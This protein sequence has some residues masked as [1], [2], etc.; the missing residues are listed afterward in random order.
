M[1]SYAIER[2]N[3]ESEYESESDDEIIKTPIKIKNMN[4]NT[5]NDTK[6]TI[7]NYIE[8]ESESDDEIIIIKKKIK[9]M[10]QN[11]NNETKLTIPNYIEYQCDNFYQKLGQYTFG[12]DKVIPWEDSNFVFSG[13]LLYDIVTERLDHNLMDIDLF[14]Y[15][16]SKSKHNTINKLLDNLDKEQYYYLIGYNGSVIYIFIQGLPRI[17]QL[18]MTDKKN[19]EEIVN[20]FDFTH[21]MSY[22]DGKKIFSNPD[23]IEQFET[24]KTIVKI[25]HKN[26]LIK[27]LDRG[28]NCKDLL[29]SNYNFLIHDEE[30]AK[31][32]KSNLQKKLY[33]STYNLTRYPNDLSSQINFTK[34]NKNRIDLSNYF[35]C[36][37]NYDK[38][39][40]HE[41]RENVNMFGSFVNYM[42]IKPN[43][44]LSKSIKYDK[45]YN[46]EIDNR[47]FHTNSDS[48]LGT[49]LS[50]YNSSIYVPCKFIKKEILLKEY[51]QDTINFNQNV[52]K[53]FLEINEI[54]II[55]YL[56]SK[57]DKNLLLNN[58]NFD[59]I[60]KK[61]KNEFK[62]SLDELDNNKIFL[63]IVSTDNKEQNKMIICA[64]LWEKKNGFEYDIDKII[65]LLTPGQ[66]IN[67]L[68]T[69]T[70]YFKYI[71][72]INK[73]IDYIDINLCP[74]YIF[75]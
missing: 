2:Y 56:K 26:R 33:N 28:I 73:N 46:I 3:S 69:I 61:D 36:R 32:I 43:E 39:D 59:F 54:E 23:T 62:K 66:N 14:F 72:L 19:P 30:K 57:I 16:D 7:S 8:S 21:V 31:I 44:I 67:C 41:F 53:I 40:N 75:S 27:Y 12:L 22:S 9:N 17:I 47:Q 5:N 63:P 10:N 15:G 6:L 37:V 48:S 29:L 58:I 52:F 24:K 1:S 64:S 11:S 49:L 13:G 38:L 68:L 70:I 60:Q 35:G 34:F 4:Q 74:E 18:I 42:H 25:L 51:Y 55:N 71:D 65:D 20:S 45:C 50:L